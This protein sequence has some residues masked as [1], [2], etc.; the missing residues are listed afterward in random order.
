MPTIST[1]ISQLTIETSLNVSAP[2][3]TRNILSCVPAWYIGHVNSFDHLQVLFT[4][5][6]VLAKLLPA[7]LHLYTRIVLADSII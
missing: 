7:A 1:H 2:T 6:R 3:T 5:T 4:A